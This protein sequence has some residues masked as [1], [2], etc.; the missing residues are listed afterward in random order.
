MRKRKKKKLI[1]NKALIAIF[2]S[3]IMVSSILS[4]IFGGYNTPQDTLEYGDYEFTRDESFWVIK[5]NDELLRFHYFPTEVE[6][7]NVSSEA[8]NRIKSTRMVYI[9]S[10][11]LTEDRDYTSLASFEMVNFFADQKVYAVQSISDNNTGYTLPLITCE[12]ATAF[13]PVITFRNSTESQLIMEE[14]CIVIEAQN[15]LDYIRIKDNLMLKYVG[16]VT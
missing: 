10:P 15:S 3:F 5:V 11:V 13:V 9:A 6:H 16:I 1:E 7:L 4:M 12:N 8:I 14:D 2:F